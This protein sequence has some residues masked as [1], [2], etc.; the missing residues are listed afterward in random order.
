[1]GIGARQVTTRQLNPEDFRG[2]LGTRCFRILEINGFDII[3]KAE[4]DPFPDEVPHDGHYVEGATVAVQ[5]NRFERDSDARRRCIEHY[6]RRCSVCE[7]DFAAAYGEIGCGFIHVHHLIPL[8]SIGQAYVVDPIGDLRP[9]CPNCHAMLHKRTPPYSL[10]E[11]RAARKL[12][13]GTDSSAA[14]S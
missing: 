12:Q 9:V 7:F 11:L 10:D 6:G 1:V 4:T 14:K 8:S 5:V 2:G 3:S 13:T